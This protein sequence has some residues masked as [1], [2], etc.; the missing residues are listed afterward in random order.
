MVR[1]KQPIR[2]PRM[3]DKLADYRSRIDAVDE[4]LLQLFNERG[5]LAIKVGEAKREA[6][7][8]TQFYR[9]EREAQVLRKIVERNPGPLA[10]ED[11]ARLI[12][13]VMSACLALE[14]RLRVAYLGPEGT[15]TQLA[16][17]KHFGQFVELQSFSAID[18]VFREVEAGTSDFGVVPIENSAEGVVTYT[19]DMLARSALRICGEVELV[20]HHHLLGLARE[21]SEIKQLLAHPQALAQCRRW[22]DENLLT[23]ERINIASNAEAARRAAGDPSIAAIAGAAAGELYGLK[24]LARNIEDEPD[25]TTRFLILGKQNPAPSGIDKSSIMFSTTNR[26]GALH[27]VLAAFEQH[28]IN[29]TRIESRPSRQGKWAYSFFVDVEGHADTEPLASALRQVAALA[30]SYRLL[31]SYPKSVL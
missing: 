13:E 7:G 29:L 22:L 21:L 30:T 27:Q 23:V 14:C 16:A 25:N 26:P 4:Q 1:L 3:S 12:R 18:V 24:T 17:E 9:P 19:L 31:G 20:V 8:E 11:V 6:G 10:N 15:F 5:R 2:A 28:R